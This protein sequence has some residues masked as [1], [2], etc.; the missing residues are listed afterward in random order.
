M[1]TDLVGIQGILW[2]K[3]F[4][5]ICLGR[6]SLSKNH[7]ILHTYNT[8]APKHMANPHLEGA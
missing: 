7:S 6:V 8:V 5:R 3:V 4:Q 1:V 2:F